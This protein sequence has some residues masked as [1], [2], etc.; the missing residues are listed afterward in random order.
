MVEE[1][2][3]QSPP[4]S[5]TSLTHVRRW[6]YAPSSATTSSCSTPFVATKLWLGSGSPPVEGRAPAACFL[7]DQL[8]RRVVPE[9]QDRVAGDVDRSLGDEAVLPEVAQAA[10][11]PRP[12]DERPP[13]RRHRRADVVETAQPSITDTLE[14]RIGS[15]SAKA[16]PPRIAH[17]RRP[18]AGAETSPSDHSPSRSS[19]SSVAKTGTPRT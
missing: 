11:R 2:D 12:L 18:S 7:D 5:D 8:D 10:V 6:V 14:T 9:L 4:R 15:P 16:P 17:Q 1:L 13:A 19:A 3:P